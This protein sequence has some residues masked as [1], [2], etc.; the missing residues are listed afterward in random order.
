L[1]Y[2]SPGTE[3]GGGDVGVVISVFV[4]VSVLMMSEWDFALSNNCRQQW[5]EANID[6]N[7]YHNESKNL[8]S[9][10]VNKYLPTTHQF[11]KGFLLTRGHFSLQKVECAIYESQVPSSLPTEPKRMDPVKKYQ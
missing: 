1:I 7:Y 10:S 6:C 2:R 4:L 3:H 11:V 8:L 9:K 5:Q